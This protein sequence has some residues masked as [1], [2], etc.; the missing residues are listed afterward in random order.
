CTGGG[1]VPAGGTGVP[2][3]GRQRL[4]LSLHRA[5]PRVVLH[6]SFSALSQ[7]LAIQAISA[8][9]GPTMARA[10]PLPGEGH[11]GKGNPMARIALTSLSAALAGVLL[12]GDSRAGATIDLLFVSYNGAPIT[13][14]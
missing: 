3:T 14:T 2:P 9:R 13:P 7:H 4:R 5:A 6:P 10:L 8:R 12:A 11:R 1:E